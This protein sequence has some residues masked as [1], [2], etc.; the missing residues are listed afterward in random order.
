P[1]STL[2]MG[3]PGETPEDVERT[4]ELVER[5]K[6]FKSLIVPLFFVPLSFLSGE[7]FFTAKDMREEHWKLY[8]ACLKHDFKWIKEL[9][10]DHF[11]DSRIKRMMMGILTN[12]IRKR[13]EPYL[14]LMEEGKSPFRD[15]SSA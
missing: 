7:R 1:C 8:A 5:L 12:F 15:G 2:V 13:L 10:R 4:R 11:K 3:L 14:K 6:E 9:A